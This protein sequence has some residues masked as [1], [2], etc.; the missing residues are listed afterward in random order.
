MN[1]SIENIKINYNGKSVKG[2]KLTV[3]SELNIDINT[4]WNEVQKS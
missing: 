2:K 3:Y 4:A 1:S